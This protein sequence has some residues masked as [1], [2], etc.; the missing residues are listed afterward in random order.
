MFPSFAIPLFILLV[1]YL[2]FLLFH[3]VYSSL[4]IL[5]LIQLGV[6]GPAMT[7][8][9]TMFA[10]VVLILIVGSLFLLASYDWSVAIQI[11]DLSDPGES[12]FFNGL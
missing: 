3:L 10:A 1:V 12:P 8:S 2:A 5:Q 7:V 6:P 11:G 9:L 4:S